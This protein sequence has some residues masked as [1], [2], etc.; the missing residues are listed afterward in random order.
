MKNLLIILTV[1][2]VV[3]SVSAKTKQVAKHTFVN[4]NSTIKVGVDTT[5]TVRNL[6][7]PVIPL[8]LFAACQKNISAHLDRSSFIL[9]YK[10]K[11]Y[12]MPDYTYVRKTYKSD[13]KD[14]RVF[15]LAKSHI[16]SATQAKHC[17]RTV[18]FFPNRHFR[19]LVDNATFV[20]YRKGIESIVFFENPGFK[21]G[22]K[23]II[24]VVDKHNKAIQ[25]SVTI[26]L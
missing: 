22:E 16:Y 14:R 6:D 26:T 8:T 15:T 11:E 17:F 19:G 20:N 24:K 9:I 4:K 21:K 10:G 5:L 7:K 2:T 12:K 1:L 13:I 23:A 25:G 18:Y 3:F